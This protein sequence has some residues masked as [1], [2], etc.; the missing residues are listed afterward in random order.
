MKQFGQWKIRRE[1]NKGG[2]GTAYEVHSDTVYY[3]ILDS[4]K[5]AVQILHGVH[6]AE[7]YEAAAQGLAQSIR[8]YLS[9]EE[10]KNLRVL[11]VL[12]EHLRTDDKAK[13]RFEQE[14]NTL[15][16]EQDPHI[17][18]I[19]DSHIGEGWFVTNFFPRGSLAD[20][21]NV[22]QGRPLEALEAFRPIVNA[23]AA[24]HA[25]NIIHRDIKPGNI[26]Y[27][28]DGL[29]LGDFGLV[30]F[31]DEARSRIS[32]KYEN[33]GSRDWMPPW[34]YGKRVDELRPSFD[35]FSLGKV[36]W[37][38]ISGKTILPLWYHR[39]RDYDLERLFPDVSHI[40]LINALLDTCIRE[41]EEGPGFPSAVE[42]LP[43]IDM[44]LSIM[45]SDGALLRRDLPR[46]CRVCGYGT[47]VLRIDE[48][49]SPGDVRDIGLSPIGQIKWRVY[50]CDKCGNLQMFHVHQ[51]PEAW[52]EFGP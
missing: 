6:V 21:L 7:S 50:V 39:R 22:F 31:A 12:H 1:I 2:Q 10:A 20:N 47:Y 18:K 46:K 11:K 16:K 28:E 40:P 17:I 27:S 32:D 13:T 5:K 42:L 45:K 19:L 41:E 51:R 48:A 23:V 43:Q 24:L 26:F 44:L 37:A 15:K 34:A 33:V 8:A 3:P 25:K 35:V 36:L 38:M 4:I 49:K 30:F 14:V 29:V 52:G 9:A